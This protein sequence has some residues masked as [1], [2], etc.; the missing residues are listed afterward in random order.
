[1]S[2]TPQQVPDEYELFIDGEWVAASGAE[3]FGT[4]DPATEEVI[5]TVAA[6]GAED[7]DAAVSNSKAALDE[8][9]SI[10][11]R[12]RGRI[13][14]D[15]AD[16]IR[17]DADRLAWIETVD[18]GKPL[19]QAKTDVLRCAEYFAYYAGM[20]DKLEG[21]SIPRSDE[22]VDYTV[23][24]PLGVTAHI[25][26]W[27]FPVGILGRGL[28]PALAAGNTVIAKPA[29]QTP[30]SALE[31]GALAVE[32]GLPAGV[33]NVLP[34]F[35]P[36]AGE[37]LVAHDDVAQVTFTGSVPT[38]RLVGKAALEGLKPVHLELGGKNPNVVYPDA[39]LD[40]AVEST[41]KSIFSRNA[42]QVCS[43]GSRL[44]LHEDVHDEFLDR[45]H[46]AVDEL[47]IASGVEDPDIAAITS[48][49]QYESIL[50]YIQIG[51]EEAGEPL[52]GGE[53]VD[54]T[55]YFIEPTIFDGVGM[56]MRI[57]REEI[58][59]P[60]L[61]VL[62]FSDEQEAIELAND[63]EYGLVSGIF[64]ND[65]GRAHRFARD[66]DAGGVYIN[67]WFSSGIEAPFGGYKNSGLGRAKGLAALE[68]YT[69]IKNVCARI[70]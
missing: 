58:F 19:S 25:I 46:T 41:V 6:A 55:G 16:A 1:M 34:G 69:Q 35:G 60:V 22:Y 39:D 50:E 53:A 11:A 37:P 10:P 56:D 47:S 45:L 13:L 17:E 64:T 70:E 42:G 52:I 38:G 51:R 27:N 9:Q 2:E 40:R 49:E 36:D 43:S 4:I 26:P 59:G 28:A 54:R 30:L 67:E 68:E 48:K 5:A 23:H 14:L 66:I 61:S 32:A 62:T 18:N 12:E 31:I 33:F 15:I 3:T 57:A 24:E 7:V 8:W 20:A 63:V 44:L 65:I 21:E 29:E